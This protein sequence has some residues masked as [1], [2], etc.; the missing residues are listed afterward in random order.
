MGHDIS[1]YR[2]PLQDL[3]KEP[4]LETRVTTLDWYMKKVE[5]HYQAGT[6]TESDYLICKESYERQ[7]NELREE[8]VEFT[9]TNFGAGSESSRIFYEVLG[10]PV[11]HPWSGGGQEKEYTVDDIPFLIQAQSRMEEI[12]RYSAA[13]FLSDII[14]H[15]KEVG[16]PVT[17][18][19]S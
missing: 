16:T 5:E 9:N 13:V 1:A 7:V 4:F 18:K 6:T 12:M 3:Y 17:I 8:P 10:I 14:T 2:Q 19:C 15:L 11:Y